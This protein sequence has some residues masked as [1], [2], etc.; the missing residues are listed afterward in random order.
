MQNISMM[1]L[2]YLILIVLF[3]ITSAAAI[4]PFG[5]ET[6]LFGA[7]F[8]E[9]NALDSGYQTGLIFGFTGER[10]L[11]RYSSISWGAS[12]IT[13]GGILRD[14]Y[15]FINQQAG[16]LRE[17]NHIADIHVRVSFVELPVHLNFIIYSNNPCRFV[18]YSGPSVSFAVHD[19]T[20]VKNKR[21]N[22]FNDLYMDYSIDDVYE[23]S[24]SDLDLDQGLKLG[25]DWG[26]FCQY[27]SFSLYSG[28]SYSNQKF[29]SSNHF[30]HLLKKI[31][32]FYILVGYHF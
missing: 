30:Q 21:T 1:K 26:V 32:Y 15:I 11:N 22:V 18:L 2:H 28:Y 20:K 12:C 23:Y 31:H 7:N 17:K 10:Y 14:K 24:K 8:S 13:K 4:T 3:S 25:F 27:R 9:L 16:E 5:V 29:K 19:F 6:I